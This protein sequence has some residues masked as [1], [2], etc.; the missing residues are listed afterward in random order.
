M[1]LPVRFTLRITPESLARWH[2]GRDG[3]CAKTFPAGAPVPLPYLVFLRAQPVIG[4]SFHD[5]LD[6][7]PDRGLYGGVS[8]RLLAPLRV[9]QT[10]Q[11]VSDLQDRRIVDAAH[12][13]LT[14][15]TL[16][17]TYHDGDVACATEAVRMIDLPPG[18]RPPQARPAPRTP[19]HPQMAALAPITRNQV[20]WLTVE[21]GD[22]NA[23][24]LDAAYAQ[25]RGFSDVVVPATLL[26]ALFERE[27]SGTRAGLATREIDVR[28]HGPTHPGEALALHA[29]IHG[30]GVAFQVFA[31][32]ALRAEGRAVFDEAT[33]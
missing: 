23:L 25:A 7:D 24:H 33:P 15:T 10:L 3:R 19:D 30:A 5:I 21:T 29:G 1:T 4:Q 17:T 13:Q 22:T 26:T 11:A 32:D 6:R 2:I 20:A 14:V 28:Y 12:G 9:G 31:G 16:L 27:L 8:Y 18:P